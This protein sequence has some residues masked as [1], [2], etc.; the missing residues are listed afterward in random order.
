MVGTAYDCKQQEN[1]SFLLLKNMGSLFYD[2]G[3]KKD[4]IVK[5]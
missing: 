1:N 3:A 4:T 5:L 2:K